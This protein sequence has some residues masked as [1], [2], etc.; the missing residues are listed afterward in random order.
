M[1]KKVVRI[2]RKVTCFFSVEL[3]SR[4]MYRVI[5][6]KKLN[7]N[8]PCTFNEKIQYLKLFEYKDS[9]LATNCADKYAVREYIKSKGLQQYLNDL[10]FVFNS[11]DEIDWDS[12]PQSFVLKCNHGCTYNILC[13]D[14]NNFDIEG[15]KKKL[16]KWMSEDFSLVTAEPHYKHIKRKI[17]CE[18][19]LDSKIMD[20][21]FFCFMGEPK[22]LYISQGIMHVD[23]KVSFFNLDGTKAN[24]RRTDYEEIDGDINLPENYDEMIDIARKLSQ[25]FKFARIDLFNVDNK[26]YFSEITLTPAS[27]MMPLSPEEYDKRLGDMIEL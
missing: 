1:I 5:M 25:D 13:P 27:G 10:Y 9:Q 22:F 6:G 2:A 20:Y 16:T 11:V 15:A 19:F 21:K 4:I 17:I 3:G 14:K 18:K 23:L 24:F 8:S 26:I 12:L 7:L